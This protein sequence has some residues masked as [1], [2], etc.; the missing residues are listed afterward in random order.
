MAC[1][2]PNRFGIVFVTG[3]ALLKGILGCGIRLFLSKCLSICRKLGDIANAVWR[4]FGAIFGILIGHNWKT[5]V[6][7][8]FCRAKSSSQ[9]GIIVR[10]IPIIFTWRLWRRRCLA[11]MEG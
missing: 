9:V 6:L 2:P 4:Y 3:E 8:W 11:R 7:T 10:I 5:T 1:F